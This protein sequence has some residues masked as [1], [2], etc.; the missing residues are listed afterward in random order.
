M[1]EG[2]CQFCVGAFG[3]SVDEVEKVGLKVI[4]EYPGHPSIAGLMAED[5]KIITL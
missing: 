2:V 1:I 4:G 5:H 3:G